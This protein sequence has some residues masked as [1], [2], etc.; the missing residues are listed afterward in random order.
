MSRH[1][2]TYSTAESGFRE[3]RFREYSPK[4]KNICSPIW[5]C[6]LEKCTP[7]LSE[8]Q[9]RFELL[10]PKTVRIPTAPI[11]GQ[12]TKRHCCVGKA[13][14]SFKNGSHLGCRVVFKLSVRDG[15]C[16]CASIDG[17]CSNGAALQGGCPT[18]AIGGQFT[19]RLQSEMASKM[20][21]KSTLTKFAL[22][23]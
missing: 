1:R 2:I 3:S 19:K 22:F 8:C 16:D 13:S 6:C 12:F 20:A 17:K 18:A 15:D 14:N 7:E 10:L 11:G 4:Q 9:N 5:R 23:C 21:S